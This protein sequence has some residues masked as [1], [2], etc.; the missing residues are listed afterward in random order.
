MAKKLI[1]VKVRPAERPPTREELGEIMEKLFQLLA[2]ER[3]ERK[4]REVNP[5]GAH[6][7]AA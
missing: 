5:N 2:E 6:H 1:K 4:R 3:A 7:D